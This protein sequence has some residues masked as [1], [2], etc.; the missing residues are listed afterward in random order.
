MIT[1][2]QETETDT[3]Y[4]LEKGHREQLN[5]LQ[6]PET[7]SDGSTSPS[8]IPDPDYVWSKTGAYTPETH[9]PTE[10]ADK[11]APNDASLPLA[12]ISVETLRGKGKSASRYNQEMLSHYQRHF[13][14]G[15]GVI[16][17]FGLFETRYCSF[18]ESEDFDVPPFQG[19]DEQ[20]YTTYVR[21][22]ITPLVTRFVDSVQHKSASKHQHKAWQ[23][24]VSALEKETDRYAI[25][26]GLQ[27]TLSREEEILPPSDSF[28]SAF[29]GVLERY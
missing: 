9:H 21:A 3:L 26:S 1:L 4:S 7:G 10:G 11:S 15:S 12:S 27:I 16:T 29:A 14:V 22:H 13:V 24:L 6:P 18:G 25:P 19:S 28:R 17:K 8:D 23:R 20:D 2:G 5:E